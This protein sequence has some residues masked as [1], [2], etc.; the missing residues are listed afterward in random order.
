MT[1]TR[2][3]DEMGNLTS[4]EQAEVAKKIIALIGD[5]AHIVTTMSDGVRVIT[6]TFPSV[7]KPIEPTKLIREDGRLICG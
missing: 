6:I 7:E 5:D 3:Y 1:I 4:K 2:E